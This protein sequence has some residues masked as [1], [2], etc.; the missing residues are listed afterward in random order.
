M[1]LKYETSLK[2]YSSKHFM[3][4]LHYR[5][6]SEC[7]I[8]IMQ[9]RSFVRSHKEYCSYSLKREKTQSTE[10]PFQPAH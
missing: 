10:Y 7:N 2:F 4:S 8:P 5:S 3:L 9:K 1:S 6:L